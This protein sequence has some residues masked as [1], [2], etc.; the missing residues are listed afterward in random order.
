MIQINQEMYNKMIADYKH[1]EQ[2]NDRLKSRIQQ[3]ENEK[4]YMRAD[5]E[6]KITTLY[7]QL[8]REVR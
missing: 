2:E 1:L 4:F 5:H 3:L 7:M 8:A 6:K